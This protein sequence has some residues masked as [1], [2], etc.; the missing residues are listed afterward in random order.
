MATCYWNHEAQSTETYLCLDGKSRVCA[1]CCV[2]KCAVDT[3]VW[4]A[5]CAEAGH[6]TWPAVR[7]RRT[8]QSTGAVFLVL[9][10]AIFLSEKVALAEV[11]NR[12]PRVLIL[13]PYDE[14]IPAT[15]IAG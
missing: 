15:D 9:L 14:R 13:Y 1:R 3:P 12:S 11:F 2:E 4:F 5:N 10:F 8:V 7:S 6:P